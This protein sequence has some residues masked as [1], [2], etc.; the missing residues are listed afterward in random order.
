MVH[1]AKIINTPSFGNANHQF[2][3]DGPVAALL[4]HRMLWKMNLP[5]VG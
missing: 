5:G 4:G 2:Y 3:L 1:A